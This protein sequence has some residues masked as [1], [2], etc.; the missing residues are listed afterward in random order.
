MTY[1]QAQ[2]LSCKKELMRALVPIFKNQ[3]LLQEYKKD[4][5]DASDRL[6]ICIDSIIKGDKNESTDSI[7]PTSGVL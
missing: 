2:L 3:M 5:S 6:F 1:Q 4:L 7:R